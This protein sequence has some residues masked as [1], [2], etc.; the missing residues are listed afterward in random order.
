MSASQAPAVRERGLSL[1]SLLVTLVIIVVAT[2]F[3]YGRTR[4]T[5]APTREGGPT[6]VLGQ[7]M[8]EG[9]EVDCA[10]NLRQIRLAI[11]MQ[12]MNDPENPTPPATLDAVRSEGIGA[13]MLLCPVTQKPYQYYAPRGQVWCPT[14][15]H[16]KF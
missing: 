14:Q 5:P 4:N 11:G 10:N 16:E 13:S 8:E 12:M 15:G 1:I 3:L 2:I 7:G 6:T 9:K